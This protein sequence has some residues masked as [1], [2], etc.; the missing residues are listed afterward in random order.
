MAAKHIL[1]DASSAY[2]VTRYE[3]AKSMGASAY[4]IFEF[5]ALMWKIVPPNIWAAFVVFGWGLVATLQASTQSF[6]TEMVC[7]WF[8]GLFEAGFGPGIPYLLSFFYLRSE[9]GFRIG[10]FLSAAPLAT[11]F[12]G[13]LAYGITNGDSRLA[14]WRLLFLVEGLPTIF[15]A[16][17][18]YFFLPVSPDR[19]RFLTEEEASVAKARAVRQVGDVARVGS[20]VWKDVGATLADLKAW[21]TAVRLLPC[22][23][24]G[25]N[26]PLFPDYSWQCLR[27]TDL[28]SSCISAPMWASRPCQVKRRAKITNQIQLKADDCSFPSYNT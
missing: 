13:A 27:L 5:Q 24:A 20:I 28:D 25:A 26:A 11:T 18:A 2:D 16:A 17:V 4:I 23:V 14:N 21:F 1:H 10:I 6:R 8:L 15:M 22:P 7:R 12:A 19:A 3:I 9:L